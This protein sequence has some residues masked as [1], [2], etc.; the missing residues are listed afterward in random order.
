MHSKLVSFPRLYALLM[1]MRSKKNHEKILYLQKIKRNETVFDLGANV[2]YYTTLFS[3]LVG[4]SG[5]VHA[6]EPLRE[7]FG[8]LQNNTAHN[9]TNL[10]LNQT[11]IDMTNSIRTIFFDPND[12]EKA[13]IQESTDEKKHSREIEVTSVDTYVRDNKITRV[14]F[15]K[16][17]IEGHEMKALKG[18]K[19]TLRNFHPKLSIEVTLPPDERTELV[20]FLSQSG[21]DNFQLIEKGYPQL[22][23]AQLEREDYFYLYASRAKS[24]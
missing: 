18:M 19:E 17:D 22:D 1:Q 12:L 4:G 16:C 5:K 21:Y 3:L 6:F 24:S 23:L 7:N 13:S 10:I 9:S 14:D 15:V 20:D 11:G 8:E 2:G